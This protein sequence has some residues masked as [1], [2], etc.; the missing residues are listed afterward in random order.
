MPFQV[1]FGDDEHTAKD[2]PYARMMKTRKWLYV[3]S[4]M[5]IALSLRLYDDKAAEDLLKV[6]ELP[7]AVVANVV[8]GGLSYMLIQYGFLT[9]QLVTSY[10]ITFKEKM[11]FR[12][13][14]EL[15]NARGLLSDRQTALA[16]YKDQR[17]QP[18]ENA[19]RQAQR[20]VYEA[21]AEVEDL[22]RQGPTSIDPGTL[23]LPEDMLNNL[24]E[25]Q[26]T[27]HRFAI[28]AA[29]ARL[30]SKSKTLSELQRAAAKRTNELSQPDPVRVSL[31]QSVLEAEAA[32]KELY[33]DDP[34][35]RRGYKAFEVGIDCMRVATPALVAISSYLNLLIAMARST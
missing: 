28:N 20:M 10:D 6:I 2:G 32:L 13:E 21:R 5:A 4:A 19:V 22:V 8:I 26:E 29:E 23:N 9:G 14:G 11:V 31:E 18:D 17:P 7:W 33:N 16:D 1:L 3:S 27:Q 34:A 35:L 12:R 24:R 25:S 30:K 15:A